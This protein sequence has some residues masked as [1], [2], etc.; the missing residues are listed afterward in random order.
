[1]WRRN[2]LSSQNSMLAGASRN[3]DQNGGLGTAPKPYSAVTA[4]TRRSSSNRPSSGC[5]CFDAHA[6]IWLT[7][8]REARDPLA[9][10][11]PERRIVLK[12]DGTVDRVTSPERLDAHRLIEE[13]MILA[14]VAAAEALERAKVPFVYRA[15]DEPSLEKMHALGE[16]LASVAMKL[17]KSGPVRATLFNRILRAVDGMEHETFINEVILRTQAQAE[18][19]AENYGHFGLNLDKYAHFTSPIRRYADLTVHR[20]LIRACGFGDD[21]PGQPSWWSGPVNRDFYT[22]MFNALGE[23]LAE[24]GADGFVPAATIGADFYRYDE[25]GQRIEDE[26]LDLGR[27]ELEELIR[28]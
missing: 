1:M 17:P 3:P 8:A 16:V 19:T 7:R 28:E 2:G 14:N 9:L 12:A 5:D 21:G 6:P 13:F 15:H 24:S 11:L 23:G 25:G 26:T 18:Y 22:A 20:A 4:A 27:P 10:D